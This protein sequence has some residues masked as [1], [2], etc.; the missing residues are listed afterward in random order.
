[1]K[2]SIDIGIALATLKKNLKEHIEELDGA[3]VGWVE[4]V[5]AELDA[6]RDAVDRKGLDASSHALTMLFHTSPKDNRKDYSKYIGALEK[7]KESGQ[8][9]V[10]LDEDD[11]DAMF[12]DNW[13]WRISSKTTNATYYKSKK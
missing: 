4:K 5:K 1:M 13:D 9:Q 2:F 3:K 8:S 6:L 7:A 10:E 12:N 11:Y